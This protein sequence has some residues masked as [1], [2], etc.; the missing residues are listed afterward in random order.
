MMS[1]GK[2][3]K[4]LMVIH[5][6]PPGSVLGL[7]LC[8]MYIKDLELGPSSKVS[9]FVD[10]PKIEEGKISE[11]DNRSN[12]NDLDKLPTWSEKWQA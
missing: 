7:F 2:T 9:N 4:F 12:Q 11:K 6:I 3:S 1:Y 10:D 8:M 5:G